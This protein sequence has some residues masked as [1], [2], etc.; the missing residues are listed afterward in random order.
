[1]YVNKRNHSVKDFVADQ[2]PSVEIF[3]DNLCGQLKVL[4][5]QD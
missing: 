3:E 4:E 1:M 5:V 2:K